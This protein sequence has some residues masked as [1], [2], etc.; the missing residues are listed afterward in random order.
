M[1]D[2]KPPHQRPELP[3]FWDH[4]FRAGVVPWEAEDVPGDFKAFSIGHGVQGSGTALVP[5]CGAAHEARFLDDL[6]WKVVAMDFSP[7]AIE[8]ARSNLAGW[9]GVLLC[10]DFFTHPMKT[11]YSLI[12]E[13]AFLCAL[14]RKLWPGY[15]ARMAELAEPGGILAGY[16]YFGDDLKGPPFAMAR[17]QLDGMLSPWFD[18][19][20]ETD[21]ADSIPVFKGRERWMVWRRRRDTP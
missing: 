21:V 18:L 14:P 17:E 11:R 5:G 16:F 13:R 12:Y 1:S 6:G 10:A 9:Q 4:R 19:A 3:D 7:A 2:C 15:G 8:R 20:A